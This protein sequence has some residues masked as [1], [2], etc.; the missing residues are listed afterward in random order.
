MRE[1]EREKEKVRKTE[2][3]LCLFHISSRYEERR[4]LLSDMWT[5]WKLYR[6]RIGP[7]VGSHERRRRGTL[8]NSD[9][10][11]LWIIYIRF[12]ISKNLTY[13][14]VCLS[15]SLYRLSIPANKFIITESQLKSLLFFNCSAN[16]KLL[17]FCATVQKAIFD[18][19][20]F[21]ISYKS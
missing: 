18:F 9:L 1:I 2:F 14:L 3:G 20:Y 15:I 4:R 21:W 6:A 7:N 8:P 19:L 5:T 13:T 11:W 10:L 17:H 12:L 16:N